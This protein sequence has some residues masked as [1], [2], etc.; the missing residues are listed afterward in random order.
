[1]LDDQTYEIS[2]KIYPVDVENAVCAVEG[3][4]EC[5][6]AK[7]VYSGMETIGCLYIGSLSVQNLIANIKLR[8]VSYEIP[9]I[10]IRVDSLPKSANGKL[11]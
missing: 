10:F 5:A 4:S 6:V 8:L 3:V 7:M 9:K 2:H 11:L 1:M